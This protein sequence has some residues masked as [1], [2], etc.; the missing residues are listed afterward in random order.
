MALAFQPDGVLPVGGHDATLVEVEDAFVIAASSH[1]QS[2]RLQLWQAFLIWRERAAHH[3]GHGAAWLSG[4]FVTTWL[5]DPTLRLV[6][7]PDTPSMVDSAIKRGDVG[8]GLLTL[9]DVIYSG[10]GSGGHVADLKVVGGM[11]D[12]QLGQAAEHDGWSAVWSMVP[13]RRR[14]LVDAGYVMVRV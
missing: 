5:E 12:A 4:T 11:M 6:F 3:F 1:Y 14:Q 10:P 9:E 2:Q 8:L 7:F 13:N